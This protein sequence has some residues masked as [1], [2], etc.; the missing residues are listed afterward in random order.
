LKWQPFQQFAATVALDGSPHRALLEHIFSAAAHSVCGS[1]LIV[2]ITG[3]TS[4]FTS[5][6]DDLIVES[7]LNPPFTGAGSCSSRHSSTAE[8]Q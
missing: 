5:V 8:P 2:P 6:L 1:L 3:A 7:G 4:T